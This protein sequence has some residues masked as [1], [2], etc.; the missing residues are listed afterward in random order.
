MATKGL[1][2]VSRRMVD[3]GVGCEVVVPLLQRD[4]MLSG[5]RTRLDILGRVV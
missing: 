4:V 3:A 2:L 1:Y 5:I